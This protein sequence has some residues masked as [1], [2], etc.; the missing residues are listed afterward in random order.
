MTYR[1]DP[2]L[3]AR[4]AALVDGLPSRTAPPV[5]ALR[6]VRPYRTPRWVLA[7]VAVLLVLA[8]IIGFLL[9]GG[10][11]ADAYS[12]VGWAST[13]GKGGLPREMARIHVEGMGLLDI[14]R[15]DPCPQAAITHWEGVS[16]MER[17]TVRYHV[18]TGSMGS[19]VVDI[20]TGHDGER[21][22]VVQGLVP[23]L[24]PRAS[25]TTDPL[26]PALARTVPELSPARDSS[27]RR[28]P[29]AP[30]VVRVAKPRSAGLD[31]GRARPLAAPH[32][33]VTSA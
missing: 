6:A 33:T 22:V 5:D 29:S 15:D 3:D 1:A 32:A 12:G 11:S 30:S 13:A 10:R 18:L 4:L 25:R 8:A 27:G 17:V 21:D 2:A 28:V 16:H 23:V 14:C 9:V 24:S 31:A 20:T 19:E 26:G 7:L